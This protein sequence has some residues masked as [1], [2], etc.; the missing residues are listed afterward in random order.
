MDSDLSD[1]EKLI[2]FR[3]I[4]EDVYNDLINLDTS[5]PKLY[6]GPDGIASLAI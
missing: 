6:M 4:E 2:H 3:S 5:G 1:D